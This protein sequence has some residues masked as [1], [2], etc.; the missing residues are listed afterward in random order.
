MKLGDKLPTRFIY[1]CKPIFSCLGR[2]DPQQ[3]IEFSTSRRLGGYPQT[4][5]DTLHFG[6]D[7][8]GGE[9]KLDP[10]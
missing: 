5:T 9:D 3:K 4:P 6:K 7:N 8:K 1:L 2:F 10:N